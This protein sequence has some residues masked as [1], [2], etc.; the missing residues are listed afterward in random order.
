MMIIPG[1]GNFRPSWMHSRDYGVIVANP[2]GRK[3]MRQGAV[4]KV[5]V[6]KG[7]PLRL[8][9]AVLLHRE[10]TDRPAQQKRVWRSCR[11]EAIHSPR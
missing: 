8:V 1:A 7:K 4:S 2:F 11:T 3:A 5:T 10:L 9:F 6:E